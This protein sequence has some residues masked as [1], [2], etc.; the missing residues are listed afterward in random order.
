[1]DISTVISFWGVPSAIMGLISGIILW[2]FKKQADKKD[3]IHEE[4]QKQL[5]TL[6]LM[7]MQSGRANSIGITALARAMKRI[8]D[9]KCN[10][11]MDEALAKMNKASEE[12]KAFLLELGIQHIFE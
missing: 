9:A 11:D 12:E 3:R 10:G 2:Y 6:M 8:P 4:Q 1:M 7:M 5:R